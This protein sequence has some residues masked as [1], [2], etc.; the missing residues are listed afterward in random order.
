MEIEK[1]KVYK[2]YDSEFIA[3]K[4][5]LEDTKKWYEEEYGFEDV[6]IEEVS[7]KGGMWIHAD[8][9]AIKQLGDLDELNT[10]EYIGSIQWSFGQV[11]KC[12]TMEEQI[13]KNGDFEKPYLLCSTEL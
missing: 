5:N 2:I 3:S 13:V 7:V 9:N 1:I 4:W 6:D 8:E 10:K 11:W 12:I